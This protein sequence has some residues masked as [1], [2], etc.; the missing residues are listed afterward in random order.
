VH[1]TVSSMAKKGQGEAAKAFLDKH[2]DAFAKA[3]I[4]TQFTS[5]M[6]K[7]QQA[8]NAIKAST[9]LTPEEKRDQ[10]KALQ[11]Q[12]TAIAKRVLDA[13]DAYEKGRPSAP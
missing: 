7:M 10:L 5:T 1:N 11:Q 9:T 3:Q 6:S 4:A 8:A 13:T 2:A 12:R